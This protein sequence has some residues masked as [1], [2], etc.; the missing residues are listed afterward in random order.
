MN[1]PRF[2]KVFISVKPRNGDFLSDQ[3]KRELVQKL[4][5]YAVAGIVPV[6]IIVLPSTKFP[7]EL[8]VVVNTLDLSKIVYNS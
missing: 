3:T 5:S 7:N 6:A 1:P 2:G 8:P 4:K